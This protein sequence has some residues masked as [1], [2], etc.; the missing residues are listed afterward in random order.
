MCVTEKKLGADM[1][2]RLFRKPFLT[3]FIFSNIILSVVVLTALSD[4][5]APTNLRTSNVSKVHYFTGLPLTPDGWTDLLAMYQ[6]PDRYNDSRIVYVSTSG[7]DSTGAVYRPGNVLMGANPFNPKGKVLP[8]ASFAAAYA[9]CRMGYPDI[10]L[11]KRGDTWN[12]SSW[13]DMIHITRSGRSNTERHII[14]AYGDPTLPRPYF[15]CRKLAVRSEASSGSNYIIAH[16]KMVYDLAWDGVAWEDS[17]SGM[18]I[19]HNSGENILVEG[20]HIENFGKTA[21]RIQSL[22]SFGI[23][24]AAARRNAF[25]NNW[26][27]TFYFN[28]LKRGLAEENVLDLVGDR[29][30]QV[31]SGSVAPQAMYL[32]YNNGN[33]IANGNIFSRCASSGIQLR[34]DGAA[35]YN[36]FVKVPMALG[37]GHA[38]QIS[39]LTV[40][41]KHN[42][43]LDGVDMVQRGGKVIASRGWGIYLATNQREGDYHY[44]KVDI[45]HNIIALNNS[46]STTNNKALSLGRHIGKGLIEN[47]VIYKWRKAI[48]IINGHNH[49][50]VLIRDNLFDG[51][52]YVAAETSGSKLPATQ[53]QFFK[54][55]YISTALPT[56]RVANSDA[57]FAQWQT[58]VDETGG[59]KLANDEGLWDSSKGAEPSVSAYMAYLGQTATHAAWIDKVKKQR[60][61]HWLPEYTHEALRAWLRKGFRRP[62]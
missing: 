62:Q 2:R 19:A 61:G 44:N 32:Q 15:F 3:A 41:A 56:F 31:N 55:Q 26:S 49:S 46:T 22:T 54:N 47:N 25:V 58:A 57:T 9:H 33:I 38:Q 18:V 37:L 17:S 40:E 12:I 14:A 42:I 36:V 34:S 51:G 6:H 39:N 48:Q 53:A 45:S 27:S 59:Q 1:K 7:D 5:T 10:I 21:F 52:D 23:D 29:W 16:L 13:A 20:C 30:N 4:A 8:F 50:G 11:F 28:S 43:I 24:M 35:N 60:Y